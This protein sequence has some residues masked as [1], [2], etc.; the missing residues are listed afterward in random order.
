MK[1][2]T[3]N[4]ERRKMFAKFSIGIVSAGL[5][6]LI[7]MKLFSAAKNVERK[8]QISISINPMAVKRASKG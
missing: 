2:D 4:F 5:L 6:S 3:V 1:Q 8:Q 7:P